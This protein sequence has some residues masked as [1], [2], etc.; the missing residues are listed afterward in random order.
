MTEI[1]LTLP[2][3]CALP[4][5]APLKVADVDVI[6]GHRPVRRRRERLVARSAAVR[7]LATARVPMAVIVA[8]AG[9]GKTTTL[10]AWER[11]DPRPF[12]W[13]GAV[14]RDGDPAQLLASVVRALDAVGALSPEVAHAAMAR[15]GAVDDAVE[16]VAGA[17]RNG[18]RPV[19]LVLDDAHRIR[20]PAALEVVTRIADALAPGSIVAVASRCEPGL[21]VGRLRAAGALLELRTDDLALD[22]REAALLLR[23][24]G[25]AL[26]PEHVALLE[27]RTEGWP[28]V[29]RLAALVVRDSPD[30]AAAAQAFAGD[31][32]VVADYL[33]DELL[34][35][36]SAETLELLV[37]TSPLEELS[38][39]VCD[40]VLGRSGSGH[41]LHGLGRRGMPI[42]ASDRFERRMR[43]H[44]LLRDLLRAE[45][46]RADPA[47]EVEIHRRASGWCEQH[48]D[49]DG[50]IRH[51]YAAG[52][53]DRLERLL[54]SAVPAAAWQGR[55]EIVTEW[56]QPLDPVGRPALALIIAMAHVAAGDRDEAERSL[57][58]AHGAVVPPAC[59][60]SAKLAAASAALEAAIAR[61][62]LT[63]MGEDAARALA[64]TD[65]G[66]PWWV[67][68]AFLDAV[69]CRLG[70]DVDAGSARLELAARWAST[71]PVL[72]ALCLAQQALAALQEDD[73]EGLELAEAARA[74]VERAALHD[75]PMS[76]LVLAVSAFARARSGRAHEARV[77][78]AAAGRL[79]ARL[80]APPPWYDAQV[81]IALARAE[82]RLSDAAAARSLLS[83]A[84]RAL[85][86]V[87]DASLLTAW[88]DDAWE[89]ADTFAVEAVSTPSTLTTAELRVLRFLPSHLSFREIAARLHVSANTV[90]TQAHAVYR[91]LDS[92]SR[93]EAVARARAV[94]LVDG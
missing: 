58:A 81:R 8:P 22:E 24:A 74:E 19:V 18:R 60:G 43:V 77:D 87:P 26:A 9:Y 25:L 53:L 65:R 21:P 7:R 13:I 61:D 63:T 64:H 3:E 17:L 20:R 55:A 44:P 51:A 73:D 15:A 71:T 59:G 45:L 68:A 62:G 46:H 36:L 94:G 48:G 33:R 40:A 89:R 72:R 11:R 39:E 35:M 29:L 93:S 90:K 91:K 32:R 14:D 34:P 23:S 42:V 85:R 79:A 28:A 10:R 2:P 12:A 37:R 5:A 52:D 69:A 47:L 16:R 86:R 1:A 56:L 57:A 67:L 50:A 27:R 78:A 92:C 38:G 70:G 75:H 30:P 83:A 6:A 49:V 76:A 88:I 80:A 31:D 41:L 54:W 66:G 82:L 4:A 84:S